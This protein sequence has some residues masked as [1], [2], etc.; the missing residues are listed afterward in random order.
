LTLR[1]PKIAEEFKAIVEDYIEKRYGVGSTTK[2]AI[3]GE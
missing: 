1:G 3:A 2:T